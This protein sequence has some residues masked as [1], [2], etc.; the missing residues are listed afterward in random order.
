C[1]KHPELNGERITS[2]G[3][4][5][6]CT[7]E[8]KARWRA[9]NPKLHRKRESERKRR[10]RATE[11]QAIEATLDPLFR[12]KQLERRRREDRADGG[13]R[14]ARNVARRSLK[15]RAIVGDPATI[16]REFIKLRRK[17]RRLGMVVDHVVPLAGCRVC[18][19][20]GMHDPSNWQLLSSSHNAAKG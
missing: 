16:D 18:G 10:R 17:A 15:R 20:R 2:H 12:E 14:K 7:R 3:N 1:N 5:V 8:A 13:R 9:A 4:C 11:P 6:A 19:A